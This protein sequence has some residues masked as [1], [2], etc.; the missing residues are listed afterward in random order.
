[1]QY[2]EIDHP[3]CRNCSPGNP[4]G[5]PVLRKSLFA[6]TLI[7]TMLVGCSPFAFNVR[8]YSYKEE[9]LY[10]AWAK[11]S[12]SRYSWDFGEY[13]SSP[14]EFEAKGGGDCED[15]AIALV[16][17]LGKDASFVCTRKTNGD[18]HVIVKY[19]DL[20]LE[21]QRFGMY[22]EKKDLKILWVLDYDETMSIST[23][24]GAK[25]VTSLSP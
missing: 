13:W 1:M 17:R 8:G 7:G 20:F 16:Y 19:K 4:K 14:A 21:P 5:E 24:W 22:Y 18:F 25:Q 12:S 3:D 23:L 2:S 10:D 9:N 11:V 6:L 15:F